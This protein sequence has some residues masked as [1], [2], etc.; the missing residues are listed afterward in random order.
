M[1][2]SDDTI[3]VRLRINRAENPFLFK[4]VS[5]LEAGPGVGLRNG[6]IKQLAEVGLNSMRGVCAANRPSPRVPRAASPRLS[7]IT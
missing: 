2:S 5:E 6:F 7:A 1:R 4:A 3:D